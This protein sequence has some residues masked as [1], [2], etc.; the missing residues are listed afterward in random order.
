MAE[1]SRFSYFAF[2]LGLGL[3]IGVLFAPRSGEET[4]EYIRT[5][6]DEGKEFLKKRS[7]ELRDTATEVVEKGKTAVSRQKENLAAAVEA[8]RQAYRDAVTGG[9]A[10]SEPTPG[11]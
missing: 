1:E 2:G 9:P 7:E 4:R 5:R 8:G 3:A 6:A 10:T 11:V